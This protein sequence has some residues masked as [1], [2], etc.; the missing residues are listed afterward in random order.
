VLRILAGTARQ[1]VLGRFTHDDLTLG[2]FKKRNKRNIKL[3]AARSVPR[4]PDAIRWPKL[5]RT[6]VL[7]KI[8]G[9]K[10][11]LLVRFVA[12]FT[13]AGITE[14]VDDQIAFDSYRLVFVVV[15][16]DAAS[17]A[18]RRGASRLKVDRVLPKRGKLACH[19]DLWVFRSKPGNG[20]GQ[21]QRFA[22]LPCAT[23][24]CVDRE[25]HKKQSGNP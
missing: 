3:F 25:R 8:L 20:L 4:D 14:P 17:E 18:P 12:T 2:G 23:M 6:V 24:T 15:E 11:V 1:H 5:G 16:V 21:F 13:R 22:Q 19:A 7:R 10:D 9:R